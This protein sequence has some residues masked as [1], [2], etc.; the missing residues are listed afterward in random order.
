MTEQQARASDLYRAWAADLGGEDSLSTA[1]K[2]VL[3]GVVASIF[4]RNGA[5]RYLASARLSMTSERI[6]PAL[7][8]FF[9][10]N[11]AA[12]KGS[13]ALGLKRAARDVPDLATVPAAEAE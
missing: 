8:V 7:E 3:A 13:L 5:E 1:Q 2:E 4:I 12:L 9:K 11:D 6:K 10:S